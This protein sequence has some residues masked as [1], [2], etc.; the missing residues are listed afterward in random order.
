MTGGML[1]QFYARSAAVKYAFAASLLAHG[2]LLSLS[3]LSR[4]EEAVDLT[5]YRAVQLMDIEQVAEEEPS[6]EVVEETAE[7]KAAPVKATRTISQNMVLLTRFPLGRVS[8]LD[9]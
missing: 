3:A 9:M 8:G 1:G 7:K 4:M 6:P 5:D 2:V